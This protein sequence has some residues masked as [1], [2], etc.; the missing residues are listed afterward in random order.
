MA[1]GE[2]S[3]IMKNARFIIVL[4]NIVLFLIGAALLLGWIYLMIDPRFRQIKNILPISINSNVENS[5]SYLELMAISTIILGFL[6]LIIGCFG[7]C[8][9]KKQVKL[10]LTSYAIIVGVMILFEVTITIYFVIFPDKFEGQLVPKLQRLIQNIYEG[11]YPLLKNRIPEPS[12][13]SVAWDLVMYNLQCCGVK[14]KTEF[15]NRNGK[16]DRTNP[17]YN[18]AIISPEAAKFTYPLTCCP[19]DGVLKPNWEFL[20]LRYFPTLAPCAIHGTGTY[21]VVSLFI[22]VRMKAWAAQAQLFTESNKL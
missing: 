16:W 12:S 7:C 22:V 20:P 1:N 4:F 9:A 21:D 10:F 14:N 5:L 18:S 11:P 19:L 2:M 3:C 15:L 6:L 13:F 17:W 8:G